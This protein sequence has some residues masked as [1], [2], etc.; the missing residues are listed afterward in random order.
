MNKREFN[1]YLNSCRNKSRSKLDMAKIAALPEDTRT[2][3]VYHIVRNRGPVLQELLTPGVDRRWLACC[4]YMYQTTGKASGY[5][6]IHTGEH[7]IR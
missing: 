5:T 1:K 7:R 4:G 6:F 2:A 3:M